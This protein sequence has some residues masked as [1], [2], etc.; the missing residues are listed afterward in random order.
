MNHLH[1]KFLFW[2]IL[3]CYFLRGWTNTLVTF[4]SEVLRTLQQHLFDRFS[5]LFRCFMPK[6]LKDCFL[7]SE[8]RNYDLKFR[9][10]SSGHVWTS[11]LPSNQCWQIFI[12][13]A[14]C[15]QE[16]VKAGILVTKINFVDEKLNFFVTSSPTIEHYTWILNLIQSRNVHS[17]K[18]T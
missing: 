1:G 12:L 9:V 14:Q 3:E 13:Q 11:R 4:D 2:R 17:Q 8:K 10:T 15:W 7:S 6:Q 5:G 16:I 18:C